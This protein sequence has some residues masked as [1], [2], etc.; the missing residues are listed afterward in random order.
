MERRRESANLTQNH[1]MTPATY[2]G[3]GHH[4][5]GRKTHTVTC[6]LH[7]VHLLRPAPPPLTTVEP[8]VLPTSSRANTPTP[9][10][11]VERL[12]RAVTS[13]PGRCHLLRTRPPSDPFSNRIVLSSAQPPSKPTSPSDRKN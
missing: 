12:H 6:S 3:H 9:V 10:S 13:T 4:H 8:L 5:H 7:F 1:F 11:T 2:D